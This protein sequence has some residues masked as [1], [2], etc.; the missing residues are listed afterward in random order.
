MLNDENIYSK[1]L[2][3]RE[4]IRNRFIDKMGRKPT[5]DEI[6]EL[7]I[8]AETADAVSQNYTK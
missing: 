2:S 3:E 7:R 1:L 8:R 4:S 6:D 5:E